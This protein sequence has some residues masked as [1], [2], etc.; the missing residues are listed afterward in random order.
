[1]A[2]T[3]HRR[4]VRTAR[5]PI[6]LAFLGLSL[7]VAIAQRPVPGGEAPGMG[8]VSADE[9]Q[10][11]VERIAK[12]LEERYV[13]PEIGVETGRHL[14]SE[15]KRGTFDRITDPKEL[16]EKLTETV[17]SVSKD[18][19]MRVVVKPPTAVSEDLVD[20]IAQYH[21]QRKQMESINYG[22]QKL[23]RLPGNVGYLD[24]R[25]FIPLAIGRETAISAM[26]FLAGSDAVIIDL[27]QNGGGNPDMVRFLC[28][29]F[30]EKPTHI[31]SLYWREG[32]R[33]EEFWTTADVPGPRLTDVPVF[34]LTSNYTFSGAEEF[35]YNMQTQKR[36]TLV[37]ETT[38]GGANPG[39]VAPANE[40][41]GIFVPT[42]RAINPVTKTNWEGV[43]VK[44]EIAVA[45]DRALDTAL[46]LA[47]TAA[48][49]RRREAGES[50]RV[51]REQ[52]GREL[53]RAEGLFAQNRS[54]E[55]TKVVA[56]ALEAAR[57]KSI[58]DEGLI[59]MLG[60]DYLQ[61]KQV[62]TAVAIFDFNTKAYP[63]SANTWDSL[64]EALM[65]SGDT[66]RA[67]ANYRRSLELDPR[68]A[69]ARAMIERM[70]EKQ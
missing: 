1:M 52:L 12:L 27:R 66:Q 47:R 35:S 68:N 61:R 57:A 45:A 69:N 8:P 48:E 9:R 40:R 46:A 15:L 32:D 6:A 60:Y 13:F 26:R 49:G 53:K 36:A 5:L 42:G 43:G 7:S 59:N 23:E 4:I 33:T 70:T 55:G 58:V 41:F 37:G 11:V 38:G 62:E 44:P 18:K 22:F 10:E 56:A 24:L 30:F 29:Y 63:E 50:L 31:N 64:G 54:D 21:R 14:T 3:T 17:Q 67:I 28:S 65:S 16:A 51:E 39:G 19:H 20:P 2:V 25:G 34:V